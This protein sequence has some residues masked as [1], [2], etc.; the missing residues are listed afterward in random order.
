V[1]CRERERERE[2][3]VFTLYGLSVD[4]FESVGRYWERER[5]RERGSTQIYNAPHSLKVVTD[6]ISI[7]SYLGT[8]NIFNNNS[9]VISSNEERRYR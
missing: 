6:F 2:R 9:S 8:R 1:F 7:I 3:S 5:E 4:R